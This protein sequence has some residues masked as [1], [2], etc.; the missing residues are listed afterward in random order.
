MLSDWR[1]MVL[2]WISIGA[3]TIL[4]SVVWGHE[5][6]K[7]MAGVVYENASTWGDTAP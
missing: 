3:I 5:T 1:C 4:L 7:E 6:M 2:L